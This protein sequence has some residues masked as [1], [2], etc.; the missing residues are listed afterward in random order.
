[1]AGFIGVAGSWL[2]AAG[3]VAIILI[4]NRGDRRL[5]GVLAIGL[6]L[7]TALALTTPLGEKIE[8]QFDKTVD[9]DRTLANRT[10]GRS[11]QW[12]AIPS[13]FAESPVWG[14]GPGTG[15]NVVAYY[16]GRHLNWHA[17]YLHI[18]AET[19]SIG[20]IAL[21]GLLFATARRAIR[22]WKAYGELAPII[23]FVVYAFLGFSVSAF[24]ANCGILLGV[25]LMGSNFT[26]RYRLVGA[27]L[28]ETEA[29]A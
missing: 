7:A 15:R 19:G 10:S 4:W 17:L 13:A 9:S 22:H 11:A 8:T 29:N 2:A 14:W 20:L 1:V 23:A 27:S 28:R 3:A 18:A 5:L 6:V 26:P 12:E 24:D 25:A 21:F 16:T